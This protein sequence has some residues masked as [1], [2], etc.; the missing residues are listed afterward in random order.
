MA[1]IS[2]RR[3]AMLAKVVSAFEDSGLT[4]EANA[5]GVV[6]AGIASTEGMDRYGPGFRLFVSIGDG[7]LLLRCS[8]SFR[9]GLVSRPLAATA[10]VF[11]NYLLQEGNLEMDVR[12]GEVRYRLSYP[13]ALRPVSDAEDAELDTSID[14]ASLAKQLLRQGTSHYPVAADA[15][16]KFIEASVGKESTTTTEEYQAFASATVTAIQSEKLAADSR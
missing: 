2:K 4:C 16:A 7:V 10:L 8:S 3:A 1:D 13:L 12:D 15:L 6:T 9:V 14:V 11:L 5:E